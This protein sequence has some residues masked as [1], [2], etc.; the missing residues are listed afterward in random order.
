MSAFFH[1]HYAKLTLE[2]E[3]TGGL[4]DFGFDRA[5]LSFSHGRRSDI[6]PMI[7]SRD[8]TSTTFEIH[9]PSMEA[10]EAEPRLSHHANQILERPGFIENEDIYLQTTDS[11]G[12]QDLGISP[13]L[14]A[15]DGAPD[16]VSGL[17]ASRVRKVRP[18]SALLSK[19]GIRYPSIPSRVVKKLAA[20]FARTGGSSKAKINKATLDAITQA[21]NW[22]F[23][24]ISDDLSA[25]SKHAGRKTIDETDV[26][27]LMARYLSQRPNS[28]TLYMQ[29]S[30]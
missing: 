19:H 24:Q 16:I 30:N 2:R 5:S 9:V 13:G 7:S 29:Q 1:M 26:L 25:Y 17:V 20:T 27:T 8:D 28:S 4:R 14:E 10:A 18:K 22:F 23:E 12:W 6:L 11:D 21:S 3:H 15:E